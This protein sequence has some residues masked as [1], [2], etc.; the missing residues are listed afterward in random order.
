MPWLM[1]LGLSALFMLGLFW[2]S[3]YLYYTQSA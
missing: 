1:I 3:D 2:L